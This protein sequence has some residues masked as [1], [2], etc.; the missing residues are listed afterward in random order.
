M[1]VGSTRTRVSTNLSVKL[2]LEVDIPE[3]TKEGLLLIINQSIFILSIFYVFG[4]FMGCQMLIML[5]LNK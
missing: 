3:I 2:K 1:V 4:Y 5:Q